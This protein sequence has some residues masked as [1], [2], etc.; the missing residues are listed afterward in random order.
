MNGDQKRLSILGSTGSVGTQTLEVVRSHPDQFNV[1]CLGANRN[2]NVLKKQILEFLPKA[3]SCDYHK[4]LSDRINFTQ[5]LMSLE[6]IA[7]HE[8]IDTVVVATSGN[9]ALIPTFEAIKSGKDIAI[10]N[11]E[12]IIMAGEQLTNLA[13]SNSVNLMPVDSEPSAIWQCLRGENKDISKLIITA[14]G[15]PFRNIPISSLSSVTPT[16]A[17]KHPTWEMGTKISVDSATMMNKAFEVIEAKWLF[18]VPWENIEVIVHPES[19]VHSMVE[20]SDGSTKAQLSYPDMRVPIQHALFFPERAPTSPVESF[21]PQ[22]TNS[23]NFEP[24]DK[25][26][27]PCFDMAIKFATKGGTWPSVL[28]GADEAA[29]SAFL[30]HKIKFTEIQTIIEEAI[31]DHSSIGAPNTSDMLAASDWG[32]K[33]VS[34]LAEG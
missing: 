25:N 13:K 21:D 6:Q 30:N 12:T 2:T 14:S 32:H 33:Q 7:T 34:D 4:E 5:T 29:V 26:R 23:L 27:F 9:V 3:I 8:E 19:I 1:V 31:K 22:K 18:D 17:L 20:F 10:A 28:T 15:G 16:D 24:L 11:K